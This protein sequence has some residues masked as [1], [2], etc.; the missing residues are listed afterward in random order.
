MAKKVGIMLSR[1]FEQDDLPG[2]LR[3]TIRVPGVDLRGVK[4]MLIDDRNDFTDIPYRMTAD[5][6]LIV[7]MNAHSIIYIE[8]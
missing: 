3:V 5:G 7:D 2:V 8:K 4:V 6:D 1:Y